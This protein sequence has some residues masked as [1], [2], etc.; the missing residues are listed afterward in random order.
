VNTNLNGHVW[1][2][3]LKGYGKADGQPF[4]DNER[5][6]VSANID[7]P[8]SVQVNER[9][10][11]PIMNTTFTSACRVSLSGFPDGG[12]TVERTEHNLD[13]ALLHQEGPPSW[14]VKFEDDSR[15]SCS[16]TTNAEPSLFDSGRTYPQFSITFSTETDAKKMVA[17]F[18][19]LVHQS[20][21]AQSKA[22]LGE[23][24]VDS[25]STAMSNA[26]LQNMTYTLGTDR[27][28]TPVKLVDGKG[29]TNSSGYAL[30]PSLTAFGNLG[31]GSE[32]DAVTVL[33]WS[34]GG[35][36][37]F[38]SLV[39]VLN[40]GGRLRNSEDLNLGDRVNIRSVTIKNRIV[41][42]DMVAQGPND[43]MCCPSGKF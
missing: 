18:R 30:V 38:S 12:T 13:N 23:S 9:K 19:K 16:Q 40:S 2:T 42:V 33:S 14:D 20:C 6:E 17:G 43:P 8:C 7:N 3:I 32:I 11:R 10:L 26:I 34:G 15:I 28:P 29:T 31:G 21:Q 4:Y 39:A 25:S 41:T 24:Q 37:E 22:G 27:D 36:G 1:S 35:S 5:D